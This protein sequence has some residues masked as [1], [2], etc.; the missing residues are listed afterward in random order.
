MIYNHVGKSCCLELN[1]VST[2]RQLV[3]VVGPL[4]HHGCPLF[5]VL[6]AV[7]AGAIGILHG[8]GQLRLDHQRV[9][10]QHLRQ[11][12][13]CSGSET[14]NA[15]HRWAIAQRQQCGPQALSIHQRSH[16]VAR[17]YA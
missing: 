7:V 3:Q 16:Q 17:P 1:H 11:D 13:A 2:R 9:T 8:M 14:V 10:F 5:Q 6:R 12:G 4:L 15:L